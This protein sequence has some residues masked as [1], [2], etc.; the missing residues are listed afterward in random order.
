MTQFKVQLEVTETR[1]LIVDAEDSDQ[2]EDIAVQIVENDPVE[3][4]REDLDIHYVV[5]T[6]DDVE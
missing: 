5:A 6:P 3:G 4:E 2:A 1:S